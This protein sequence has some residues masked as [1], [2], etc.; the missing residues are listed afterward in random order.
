M[1]IRGER[2]CRD[3]GTRWSYYETGSVDCPACGS[4]LS[5]GVDE[6]TEHTSG[7]APF[8]LTPA[9][10]ALENERPLQE[11][12]T[13]ASDVCRDFVHSRGFIDAGELVLLDDTFLAAMELRH[14]ADVVGRSFSPDEDEEL[15]LLTLLRGAD[16]G[17][18]PPPDAVPA[19]MRGAH[20]LAAAGA[21]DT[22]RREVRTALGRAPDGPL[23]TVLASLREH[24]RRVRALDGEVP[25]AS[26]ERLVRATKDVGRHLVEDE[27]AALARARDRL[28]RLP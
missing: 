17:E 21:V 19:S 10:T 12:V 26:A 3:C 20:G 25:I 4:L 2:E 14:V 6:R 8:D 7:P 28:D 27:E 18:R 23:G 1:R 5:V 15:Y 16:T 13:M 24:V 11:V 9:R 22:Y